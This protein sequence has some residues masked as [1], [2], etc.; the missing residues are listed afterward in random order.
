MRFRQ[1]ILVSTIDSKDCRALL[2]VLLAL[3]L[4]FKICS[5]KQT[6]ILD[7]KIVCKQKITIRRID[8][9]KLIN[10]GISVLPWLQNFST[11]RHNFPF[12]VSLKQFWNKIKKFKQQCTNYCWTINHQENVQQTLTSVTAA[13]LHKMHL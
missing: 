9:G 4:P 12:K 2:G 13:W 7:K 11:V 10:F 1:T 6:H 3:C 8:N 5:P